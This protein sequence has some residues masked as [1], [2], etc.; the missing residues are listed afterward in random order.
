MKRNSLRTHLRSIAGLAPSGLVMA[1]I[2]LE[3]S[4]FA[5]I[6]LLLLVLVGNVFS[7][8]TLTSPNWV[9]GDVFVGVGNHSY[10]VWHS[11]NPTANNPT[12]TLQTSTTSP[13]SDGLGGTTAGCG[14]DLG[15]RFFG[16]N[17]ASTLVD[18]YSIDNA[19]PIVEK[20]PSHT[21]ASGAQSVAFDGTTTL[22]I[23]YAGGVL[24]GNGTIEKWT[25][26]LTTGKYGFRRHSRF[27]WTTVAQA[28]STLLPMGI[29]S[30]TL[31]SEEHTSE[32]QSR[33]DLVCRLLLEK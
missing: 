15:Y 11:A 25:K 26:D 18:R 14:F 9:V 32:L 28:G 20:I 21:G 4:V 6:L 17:F 3:R 24:G 16:T 23:G 30:F 29:R 27:R 7:Q 12:Y 5:V 19:H 8:V 13:L 31:R 22:Y 33:F 2:W 1:R 10:Q